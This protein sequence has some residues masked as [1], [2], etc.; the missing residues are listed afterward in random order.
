MSLRTLGIAVLFTGLAAAQAPAAERAS[1]GPNRD[2]RADH[3]IGTARTPAERAS[4]GLNQSMRAD[5][6]RDAARDAR[7]DERP[8]RMEI[9]QFQPQR[10]T[11]FPDVGRP[12]QYGRLSTVGVRGGVPALGSNVQR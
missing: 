1:R 3:T 5:R 6:F 9:Q 10:H 4:L 12:E 11:L 2:L 7:G 8:V